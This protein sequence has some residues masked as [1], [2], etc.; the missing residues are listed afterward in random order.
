MYTYINSF[1]IIPLIS[2]T[3]NY[4]DLTSRSCLLISNL[5][6]TSS[7]FG[8]LHIISS[9]STIF[10]LQAPQA[11]LPDVGRVQ[12]SEGG[13][14]RSVWLSIT[15]PPLWA[16]VSSSLTPPFSLAL[17]SPRS[18]P[19]PQPALILIPSSYTEFT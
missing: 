6:A 15:S 10:N 13:G 8:E 3:V 11:E 5:L 9:D 7:R 17:L 4:H 14:S 2:F 1:S 16:M 12:G 19:H 18:E